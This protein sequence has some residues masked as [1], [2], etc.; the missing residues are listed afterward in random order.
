[1]Q[2]CEPKKFKLLHQIVLFVAHKKHRINA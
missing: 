2:H 1:M